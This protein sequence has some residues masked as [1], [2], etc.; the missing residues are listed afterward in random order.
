MLVRCSNCDMGY[1]HES[2]TLLD[3]VLVTSCNNGW[4]FQSSQSLGCT[5]DGK[6]TG[7]RRRQR[8]S[9]GRSGATDATGLTVANAVELSR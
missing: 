5:N 8:D 3:I 1:V 6:S 4:L 7:S 9:A 2:T